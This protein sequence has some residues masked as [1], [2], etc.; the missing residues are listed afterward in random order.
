MLNI[1]SPTVQDMLRRT[2]QGFGNMP[3][4]YGNTP[5][6]TTETVQASPSNMQMP[7]PSPKEMIG[8]NYGQ[9]VYQP[10]QF[11]PNNNYVGG[12]T[13]DM[14]VFNGYSNPYMG[15]GTYDGYGNNNMVYMDDDAR[16]T[17]EVAME[18]GLT[19]EE[20][21]ECDSR[22]Y[23]TMSRIVSKNMNRTEEE[24]KRCEEAFSIYDKR[25]RMQQEQDV[26]ESKPL[27][28]RVQIVCGDEVIADSETKDLRIQNYTQ[29]SLYAESIKQRSQINKVNR[30]NMMIQMYMNAPERRYD[31]MNLVDFFN[32]GAGVL[33][34]N[35]ELERLNR[36]RSRRVSEIYN[37]EGFRQRL[38]KNNGVRGKEEMKAVERF[39][40]RYGVMPDGRPVSPGH[41]PAVA[42]SFSYDPN[43]GQYSVTAPNF[44]RDRLEMARDSFIKSIDKS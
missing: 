16:E 8:N 37:K 39:V 29:N 38:L 22:L 11:V 25:A 35:M 32:K 2:P 20:Q 18:N 42:M 4:Y 6:V 41:D 26:R 31:N 40:G 27:D 17:M 3:V 9:T 23:K 36:Q 1:N 5:T 24:A 21:L 7:Y 14:S 13:P 12:Y 19:Y 15:Y 34:S 30:E 44:I 28:L 10:T 33:Y 43:T